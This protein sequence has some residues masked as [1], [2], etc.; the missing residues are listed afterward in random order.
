[1]TTSAHII[2]QVSTRQQKGKKMSGPPVP[3]KRNYKNRIGANSQHHPELLN[4][5]NNNGGGGSFVGGAGHNVARLLSHHQQ[6]QQQEPSYNPRHEKAT[7]SSS[8]GYPGQ[9]ASSLRRVPSYQSIEDQEEED[10]GIHQQN[11]NQQ[12]RKQQSQQQ[13]QQ[14]QQQRGGAKPHRYDR[15]N[16]QM[17]DDDEEDEMRGVAASH[18]HSH[19]HSHQGSRNQ[20]H[21]EDPV[22]S[23]SRPRSHHNPHHVNH[24]PQNNNYHHSHLTAEEQRKFNEERYQQNR[25]SINQL[26]NVNPYEHDDIDEEIYDFPLLNET[27]DIFI[28]P[29]VEIKG[30]FQYEGLLRLDGKFQGQFVT[31][32]GDLIIGPH[33]ILVS[34][35]YPSIRRLWIDGG[36]VYGQIHVHQLFITGNAM[37][38][39]DI[40]CKYMQ[41]FSGDASIQGR[42]FVHNNAPIDR[43]DAAALLNKEKI[44]PSMVMT[45]IV[46][47]NV[48]QPSDGSK[49]NGKS[50]PSKVTQQNRSSEALHDA[51]PID[52]ATALQAAKEAKLAAKQRRKEAKQLLKQELE[53]KAQEQAQEIA[54][55]EEEERKKQEEKRKIKQQKAA[56]AMGNSKSLEKLPV[57]EATAAL[58][59]VEPVESVGNEKLMETPS[60]SMEPMVEHKK[61]NETDG[62]SSAGKKSVLSTPRVIEEKGWKISTSDDGAIEKS[63]VEEEVKAKS[64]DHNI[65]SSPDEK[66]SSLQT[67]DSNPNLLE[68]SLD[69]EVQEVSQS[70]GK[71]LSKNERS[72]ES[73]HKIDP[74][75]SAENDNVENSEEEII[76]T[77]NEGNESIDAVELATREDVDES[78][79]AND[80]LSS[81]SQLQQ[82][83][84]ENNA[85]VGDLRD[86]LDGT[87]EDVETSEN[88][89]EGEN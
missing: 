71:D 84:D 65:V 45:D 89:Q 3:P 5:A 46:A 29:E 1:M 37:I 70:P 49:K 23:N 50:Q 32:Q 30:D 79:F 40:T 53:R 22:T 17:T 78:K 13:Q 51:S 15:R 33:A 35:L 74:L 75:L 36:K 66:K 76:S 68:D 7:E 44:I 85:E 72:I 27:P 9:L 6:Q 80:P 25:Q 19:S 82:E 87:K 28:G 52:P 24:D 20:L 60:A 83:N 54:Q 14:Q 21:D 12:Q 63:E 59:P 8:S 2:L 73:P 86:S 67:F 64:E 48:L 16:N 56:L 31:E 43:Q 38:K 57:S 55:R 47:V 77:K 69:I 58:Q 88:K 11:R 18:S 81:F 41:I 62:D 4:S 39:G 10:E 42:M 61:S 34:D 26:M